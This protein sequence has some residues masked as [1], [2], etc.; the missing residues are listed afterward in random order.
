MKKDNNK[1]ETAQEILDGFKMKFM[2][3]I[4]VLFF[5]SM[6]A[7]FI[8]LFFKSHMWDGVYCI[9]FN[10]FFIRWDVAIQFGIWSII[11]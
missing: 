9:T 1:Q 3:A 8:V 6:V 5:G 7:A 4:T 11:I 10:F 2:I